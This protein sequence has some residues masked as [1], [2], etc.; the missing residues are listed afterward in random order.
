M[1]TVI[2]ELVTILSFRSDPRG[3]RETQR[4]LRDI[5]TGL[6]NIGQTA[7]VVGGLITGAFGGMA[8]LALDDAE[9]AAK[10][11]GLVGLSAD[12]AASQY[13]AA[14]KIAR[15]MGVD[16]GSLRNALFFI[17]SNYKDLAGVIP[18]VTQAAKAQAVGLGDAQT[19]AQLATEALNAYKDVGL[20]A[21]EIFDSLTA[22][23]RLGSLETDSLGA[24]MGPLI[25]IVSAMGVE[26]SEATGLLA[27]MSRTGTDARTGATQLGQILSSF[28]DPSAEGRKALEEYG[29][30][31]EEIRASIADRGVLDTLI[32]LR[33]TFGDNQDA[34]TAMFG[35]IRALRGVFDLLGPNLADTQ[36][37][38]ADMADTS[39][40]LDRA[41]RRSE[42]ASRDVAR[43]TVA[44]KLA[45]LDIG[46]Q[47]MPMVVTG[48]NAVS[49]AIERLTGWMD[50]NEGIAA[51]LAQGGL[52]LGVALVALSGIAYALS[53]ALGGLRMVM[54]VLTFLVNANTIAWVRNRIVKAG[55][56]AVTIGL[57]IAHGAMATAMGVA[58]AAVWLWNAGLVAVRA[59]M[60]AWAAITAAVTAAQW[61]LNVALTANPIGL[62]IVAIA[63][64]I[65]ALVAIG[66][67]VW[68]FRDEILAAFGQVWEWIKSVWSTIG[69]LI[70]G[71]FNAIMDSPL[72]QIVE[73][74][75][76]PY[77]AIWD[78]MVGW[79]DDLIGLIGNLVDWVTDKFGGIASIVGSIGGVVSGIGDRLGFEGGGIVPGGTG[80]AVP[81]V[82]HG[83]EMVLP[84]D[85][86]AMLQGAAAS[87][88]DSGFDISALLS[89]LT[90]GPQALAPALPA[91][92][93]TA[94]PRID[95]GGITVQVQVGEGV[96]GAG[97]A[98][99]VASSIGERLREQIEA[100]VDD[101]DGPIAR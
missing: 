81:A 85:I 27:A 76:A 21:E 73:W 2:D 35:N 65:A 5:E 22:A 98:R 90:A 72:G 75:I 54:G 31:V 59:V 99:E 49:S 95:V 38:M 30:S 86:S 91:P 78:W 89:G 52:L 51:K 4:G 1:A 46:E 70:M 60:V 41:Y 32:L 64:A 50:E 56:L 87:P 25:P 37:I 16:Y 6:Q 15:E 53:F 97:I 19:T 96:D 17:N 23:I 20:E 26:F 58:T 66:F 18:I 29:L 57:A 88:G 77:R 10:L 45:M 43:A 100:L 14:R 28:L 44:M 67:A 79:S 12:E 80:Q 71:P 8:K 92:V 11:I 74:W 69:D 83:G 84:A 40:E 55:N 36:A 7:L 62:I 34:M 24:A 94:G 82:L 61:A 39:G 9:D 13:E 93:P 63:A 48:A 101:F 33:N 47:V 3:I 42:N 68:Y